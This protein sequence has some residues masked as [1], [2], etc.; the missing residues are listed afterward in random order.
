M[1]TYPTKSQYETALKTIKEYEERQAALKRLTDDLSFHLK[2]FDTIKFKLDK[3]QGR[4]LF[5][6]VLDG[7]IKIGESVCSSED[8]FNEV[9]GKLISVKKA[10]GLNINDVIEH[11]ENKW[12]TGGIVTFNTTINAKAIVDQLGN[13]NWKY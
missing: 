6:G 4:V 2:K 11:V 1:S 7:Q 9:I 3:K 8:V 12:A 10:L 5:T 13:S